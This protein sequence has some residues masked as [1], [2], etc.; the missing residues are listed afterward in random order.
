MDAMCATHSLSLARARL[1]RA[2]SLALSL[3]LTLRSPAEL[4]MV[5]T[6]RLQALHV[7]MRQ[8]VALHVATSTL[9]L[10]S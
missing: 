6:G 4:Q 10:H 1:S 9:E 5:E 7:A 2:R 3:S 8:R